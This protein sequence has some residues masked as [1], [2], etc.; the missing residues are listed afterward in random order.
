MNKNHQK[1]KNKKKRY[2]ENTA[3]NLCTF[4]NKNGE[5]VHPK[6]FYTFCKSKEKLLSHLGFE[7]A[8]LALVNLYKKAAI[9]ANFYSN[10]G[11]CNLPNQKSEKT[12]HKNDEIL[13]KKECFLSFKRFA[14]TVRGKKECLTFASLYV[15]IFAMIFG[16][17]CGFARVCAH[18]V[19]VAAWV[20]SYECC[21]GAY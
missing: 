7:K 14:L 12:Y 1:I 8:N 16:H 5:K 11:K 20:K 10:H 3:S 15:K 13:T 18:W 6:T 19:S 9:S 21:C 4:N 2:V 17:F